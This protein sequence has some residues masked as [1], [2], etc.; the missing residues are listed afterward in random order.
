MNT[1]LG[2]GKCSCRK[3]FAYLSERDLNMKLQMY[4]KFCSNPLVSSVK[5]GM[6]KKSMMM[7]DVQQYKLESD[8]KVHK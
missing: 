7:E 6:P 3:S 8:R 5:V 1:N 4:Y 2:M